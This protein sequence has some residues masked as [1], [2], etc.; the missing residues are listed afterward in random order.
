MPGNEA[1]WQAIPEHSVRFRDA[2]TE[3]QFPGQ[4]RESRDGWQVCTGSN[5]V[6]AV[7]RE[8]RQSYAMPS[9]HKVVTSRSNVLDDGELAALA[10]TNFGR[11]ALVS[12]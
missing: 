12:S 4:S 6:R 3:G 8:A 10:R 2:G 7:E 5:T 1:S 11:R 9:V